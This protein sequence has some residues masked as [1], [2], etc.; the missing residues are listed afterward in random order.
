MTFDFTLIFDKAKGTVEIGPADP[1]AVWEDNV[2]DTVENA[3]VTRET[4]SI[5]IY[6]NKEEVYSFPIQSAVLKRI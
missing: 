4:N 6:S 1:T 5:V 2:V 3:T